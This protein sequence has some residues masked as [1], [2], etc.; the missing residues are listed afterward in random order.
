MAEERGDKMCGPL[1]L[2]HG[3]MRRSGDL[4]GVKGEA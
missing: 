1:R 2:L 3:P 4:V